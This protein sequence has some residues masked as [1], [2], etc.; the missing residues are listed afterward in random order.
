MLFHLLDYL[1]EIELPE[2]DMVMLEH[3]HEGLGSRGHYV[4]DVLGKA[5]PLCSLDDSY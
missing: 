2:E 3:E 4:A 5:V 1:V